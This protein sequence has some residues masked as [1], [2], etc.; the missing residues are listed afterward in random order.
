MR[1]ARAANSA[2]VAEAV[3]MEAVPAAVHTA[4]ATT[5]NHL[6]QKSPVRGIFVSIEN[7]EV[8]PRLG[9]VRLRYFDSVF[10]KQKVVQSIVPPCV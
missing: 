3:V 10:L 6:H 8:V 7:I 1:S 2:P 4:A 5:P 9:G